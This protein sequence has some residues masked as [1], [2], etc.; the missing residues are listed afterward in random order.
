MKLLYS[1]LFILSYIIN[2]AIFA[3]VSTCIA[4]SQLWYWA[5]QARSKA[6]AARTDAELSNLRNQI[7]PHFLL[8]TLNNIYAL[9]AFDTEKAQESIR[10]L[11][12]MLR[13]ILYDYQQPAVPLDDEIEFIRNYVKL[14]K[15]RLPD[16]IKVTF[17][18]HATKPDITIAPMI[19]ISLVENAFKHGVSPTEPSFIDIMIEADDDNI[20]CDI[21]NSNY[22]KT[23]SDHSGHGIGLQQIQRRLELAYYEHYTWTKEVVNDGK[24]YHS[25]IHITEWKESNSKL[26]SE[27]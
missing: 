22:P 21:R 25:R 11:S 9:T 18:V 3:T 5:E 14:M 4:L 2:F 7:N 27:N 8:N 1:F 16:S 17:D 23:A 20:I 15:L 24:E 12:N 10:E 26:K 13:H 19:F 6:E